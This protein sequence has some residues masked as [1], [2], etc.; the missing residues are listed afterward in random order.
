MSSATHRALVAASAIGM[1]SVASVSVRAQTVVPQFRSGIDMVRIDVLVK[2]EKQPVT[3]MAATD[4]EVRDNGILQAVSVIPPEA[5]PLDIYLAIDVSASVSGERLDAL[6]D[7]AKRLVDASRA[8]DRVTILGFGHRLS[9]LAD[10]S[11]DVGALRQRLATLRAEGG[12]ALNDAIV[13]SLGLRER[14]DARAVLIVFSDGRDTMSWTSPSAVLGAVERADLSTYVVTVGP[15]MAS[16]AGDVDRYR[17]PRRPQDDM[18]LHHG[19]FLDLLA[20]VGGGRRLQA[21]SADVGDA[22]LQILEECR[23]RYLLVF[24]PKSVPADGWHE[25]EVRVHRQKGHV[26]ARRGYFV[27]R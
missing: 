6:I 15:Q 26:T 10:R 22:F 18:W 14:S 11:I 8:D 9:L 5:V 21:A 19:P 27:N 7:A 2:D 4:F 23:R 24:T 16:E 13:A 12:T 17:R 25:L 1:L 20:R 3:G